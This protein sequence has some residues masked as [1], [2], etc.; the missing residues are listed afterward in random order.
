[1]PQHLLFE[2]SDTFPVTLRPTTYVKMP[3]AKTHDENRNQ[4]CLLCF[5][6][7]KSMFLVNDVL[8]D[9]VKK[10]LEYDALDDRLPRVLCSTCKRDLYRVEDGSEK[11]V[12]LPKFSDLKAIRKPTRSSISATCDCFVC[13]LA[14]K[15]ATGNF[16]IGNH[17]PKRKSIINESSEEISTQISSK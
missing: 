2:S 9:L 3:K 7:T 10:Y 14:R 13:E 1:M 11:C 17:L 4:I 8:K 12:R 5:G 6:K 15:P 16:A